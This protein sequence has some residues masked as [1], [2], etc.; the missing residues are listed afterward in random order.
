MMTLHNFWHWAEQTPARTA[1]IGPDGRQLTFAELD[2][3]YR[4]RAEA[5]A[6]STSARLAAVCEVDD[7][8][9]AWAGG[10]MPVRLEQG[11]RASAAHSTLVLD[12]ANSTAVLLG[13]KLGKGVEEVDVVRAEIAQGTL[14]YLFEF[15]TQVARLYGCE[16]AN[17]SM[18][19]GSTA[20]A[21]AVMM[22]FRA[23]CRA[24]R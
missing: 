19:D 21:E 13:G 6:G 24:A 14:Q 5:I 18:Y 12:D 20:C 17:A 3:R 1:V 16:V 23:A 7:G 15:Q 22:A 9:I 11:L 8:R 4:A 2:A 10:L